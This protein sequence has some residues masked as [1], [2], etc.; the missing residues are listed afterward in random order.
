[1]A[2]KFSKETKERSEKQEITQSLRN[3][4]EE[5][6]RNEAVFNLA[7]SP[8]M[9]DFAVHKDIALKAQYDYLL[10]KYKGCK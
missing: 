8:E 5:L 7:E 4:Q 2:F 1:M 9:I 10:K 6:M 3:V